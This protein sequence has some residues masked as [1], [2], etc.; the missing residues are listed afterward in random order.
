M[1][2]PFCICDFA[3]LNRTAT[4]ALPSVSKSYFN[5]MHRR[6]LQRKARHFEVPLA[7]ASAAR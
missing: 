1:I 6:Y 3:V 2:K 7:A 5:P 4:F